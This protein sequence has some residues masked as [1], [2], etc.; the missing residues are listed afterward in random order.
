MK[1]KERQETT[2]YAKK[3]INQFLKDKEYF[4]AL[5]LASIYVNTRLRT[6]LTNRLSPTEE[7]WEETS[8]IVDSL[9]GFKKMVSLCDKLGLI[10]INPKTLKNLW[11]ERSA[12]AHES[13]LWKED[14]LADEK[15]KEIT[16]LCNSAI[17]FLEKTIF[18]HL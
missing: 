3:K 13:E 16:G 1:I 17:E 8:N 2:N 7:K 6:L 11:D 12:V 5:L 15:I 9:Y 14:E 4:S 10:P 18:D